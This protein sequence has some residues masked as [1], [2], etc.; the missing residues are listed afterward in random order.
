MA[1]QNALNPQ[2]I[3][4]IK[5]IMQNINSPQMQTAMQF[6]NGKN[7]TPKQAVEML[8]KQR[9]INVDEFMKQINIDL[10]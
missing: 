7:I 1:T 5:N 8:C 3:A 4:Q 9:G 2:M 10:K 6:L